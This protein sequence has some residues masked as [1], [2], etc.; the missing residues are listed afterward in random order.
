MP[1]LPRAF[2]SSDMALT[3]SLGVLVFGAE[4]RCAQA[5]LTRWAG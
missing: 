1:D 2:S 4:A 5:V 3:S